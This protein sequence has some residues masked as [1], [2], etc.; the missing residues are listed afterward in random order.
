MPT[1]D[2]PN[3][4]L[5]YIIDGPG[6]APVTVVLIHGLCCALADWSSQIAA[7]APR[8]RVLACDLRGHGASRFETGF[9]IHTYGEDVAALLESLAIERAVLVGHSMGCRVVLQTAGLV[10]GRVRA[11]VLVDGSRFVVDDPQRAGEKARAFIEANGG[12]DNTVRRL[13]TDMF[14]AGSDPEYMATIV[15]RAARVPEAVGSQLFASMTAWDAGEMGQVLDSLNAELM[16]VQ[17][18]CVNAARERVSVEARQ[19]NPWLDFVREHVPG[20]RIE[21]VTGVGH[22]SQIEAADTVNDLIEQ[23]AASV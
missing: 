11:L 12:W 7:L 9:D 16:V 13:F 6:K 19:T 21:L 17:S 2:R 10:P 5:N 1:L 8:H 18:T 20:A 4:S 23:M 15:E 3:G 14:I 22:F